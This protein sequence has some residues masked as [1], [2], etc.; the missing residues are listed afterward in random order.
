MRSD[1][2]FLDKLSESRIAAAILDGASLDTD[3][4]SALL[5]ALTVDPPTRLRIDARKEAARVADVRTWVHNPTCDSLVNG[6]PAVALQAGHGFVPRGVVRVYRL[7]LAADDGGIVHTELVAVHERRNIGRLKTPSDVRRLIRASNTDGSGDRDCLLSLFRDR[8][9]QASTAC[10]RV[11]AALRERETI[12]SAPALSS[13]QQLVQRGL[14]DRRS[15]GASQHRARINAAI[16]EES[17]HRIRCLTSWGRTTASLKL[18]AIL[19]V[20]SAHS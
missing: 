7:T 19:L 15:E 14:F 12:V 13:A 10:A 18:S 5:D 11:G 20:D 8:I 16:L 17:T 4:N 9:Q 1:A 6:I 3:S 2:Q